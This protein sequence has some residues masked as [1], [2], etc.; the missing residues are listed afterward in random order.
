MCLTSKLDT[1]CS[2]KAVFSDVFP[3]PNTYQVH[4]GHASMSAVASLPAFFVFPK[5]PIDVHAA[6]AALYKALPPVPSLLHPLRTPS[7]SSSISSSSNSG[8]DSASGGEGQ[9]PV[10]LLVEQVYHHAIA[11]LKEALDLLYQV[12]CSLKVCLAGGQ[13]GMP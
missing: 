1:A 12:R 9:P 13:A 4:Y 6:A 10:V 2:C 7:V 11:A 5:T 8:E 3:S